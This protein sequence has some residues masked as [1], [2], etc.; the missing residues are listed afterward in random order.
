MLFK[1]TKR[2]L[3]KI[4]YLIAN[5][6][7]YTKGMKTK[8][9]LCIGFECEERYSFHFMVGNIFLGYEVTY[10]FKKGIQIITIKHKDL[11]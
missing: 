1:K 8:Y 6:P 5:P 11:K 9:G 4:E 2:R 3:D 7:L 10:A